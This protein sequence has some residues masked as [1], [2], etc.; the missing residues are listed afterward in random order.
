[1]SKT[2]QQIFNDGVVRG[3][4]GVIFSDYQT[5]YRRRTSSKTCL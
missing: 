5:Q 3:I 1:L 2:Q 4:V